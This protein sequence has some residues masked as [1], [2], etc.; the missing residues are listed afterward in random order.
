M[1][2]HGSHVAK[3]LQT[4]LELK[5]AGNDAYKAGDL[6]T[7]VGKY[8]LIFAYVNGLQVPGDNPM[9]G[10]FGGRSSA[11]KVDDQSAL[12]IKSLQLTACMNLCSCYLQQQDAKRS[13]TFAQKGMAIDQEDLRCL[14]RYGKACYLNRMFDEAKQ[15]LTKA[16]YLA[17]DGQVAGIERTLAQVDAMLQREERALAQRMKK[18]FSS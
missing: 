8:T 11:R 17:P 1:S 3:S 10:M 5:A 4:A 12:Q 9:L 13:L 14:V 18:M 15:S 16:L 6:K 7:A 2:D